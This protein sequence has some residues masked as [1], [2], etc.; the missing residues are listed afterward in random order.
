MIASV[1]YIDCYYFV[2]YN[3]TMTFSIHMLFITCSYTLAEPA[4]Q[5]IHLG[6]LFF[7]DFLQNSGRGKLR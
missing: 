5:P 6:A 2:A 4:A 7:Q 1:G 3:L